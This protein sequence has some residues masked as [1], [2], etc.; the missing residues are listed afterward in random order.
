MYKDP[1]IK[2]RQQDFLVVLVCDGYERIPDSFKQYATKHKFFDEDVLKQ[3]GFLTEE[4]H[5]VLRMKTM[6]ELMEKNVKEEDI[7]KNI[8]HL[9]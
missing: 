7:P 3:Q 6:Q 5:G 9:F 1:E 2:M 8:L 4:R